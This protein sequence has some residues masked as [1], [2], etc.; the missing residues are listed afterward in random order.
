MTGKYRGRRRGRRGPAFSRR[1]ALSARN[2]LGTLTLPAFIVAIFLLLAVEW[3]AYALLYWVPALLESL[4]S[5]TRQAP[6]VGTWWQ[7]ALV[8]L[9]VAF[10]L[11]VGWQLSKVGRSEQIALRDERPP[12]TPVLL[13]FLSEHAGLFGDPSLATTLAREL[14]ETDGSG[15]KGLKEITALRSWRM[16]LEAIRYHLPRLEQVV[17]VGSRSDEAGGTRGSSAQYKEFQRLAEI[18]AGEGVVILPAHE[19]SPDIAAEGVDFEDINEISRVLA[20][21]WAEL[22]GKGEANG[23]GRSFKA[24]H[25]TVDVT[26]GNKLCSIAGAIFTQPADRQC[27]YILASHDTEAKVIGLD[28][29]ADEERLLR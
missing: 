18:L 17:L 23:T 27:Q 3:L 6:S 2:L 28:L 26:G 9:A 25:I 20:L 12:P 29:L 16:P 8:V 15:G 14:R 13:L 21:I 10:L 19:L 7:A 24:R 11:L 4:V 5:W 22:T 1:L